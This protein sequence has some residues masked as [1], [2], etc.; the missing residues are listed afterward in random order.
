MPA[1]LALAA[2]A[3][4]GAGL[5]VWQAFSDRS[6][7]VLAAIALYVATLLG[8][9]AYGTL[10][11]RFAVLPTSRCAKRRSSRTTSTPRGAPSGSTASRN[12]SCPATRCSR[13]ADIGRNA[14]TLENV[15]LWDHQPLLDTFGQLQEIRT[16]Y[17][18]ASVD[19]DRY[20]IER[21]SR[22]VMLSA[23]ELNSRA[24]PTA[25]G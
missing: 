7:P 25:P 13:R 14:A 15:R 3:L 5:A 2:V 21:P 10:L 12:R 20:S 6:W 8:G 1:S 22:Q 4:V 24:C 17:D 23:R 16:Y 9:E 19:N 18:F 11:Q